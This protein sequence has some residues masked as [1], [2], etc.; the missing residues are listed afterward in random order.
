MSALLAPHLCSQLKYR[1]TCNC[2]FEGGRGL[3]N[4][5]FPIKFF[6][7]F[8]PSLLSQSSNCKIVFFATFPSLF[9]GSAGLFCRVVLRQSC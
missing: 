8:P 5:Y 4:Y 7:F 2:F 9:K 3:L 1:L 6:S